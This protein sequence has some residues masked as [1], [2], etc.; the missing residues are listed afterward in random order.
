M[1]TAVLRSP[2]R[3]LLP[4]IAAITLIA[5]WLL[6][7]PLL[8]RHPLGPTRPP[9]LRSIPIEAR[10][11]YDRPLRDL[12]FDNTLF[13][14]VLDR[15]RDEGH[16]TIFVNW[17]ALEAAGV[18]KTHAITIRLPAGRLADALTAVT[19]QI[20]RELIPLSFQYDQGVIVISTRDDLS[21][22]LIVRVYDVRDLLK[23]DQMMPFLRGS[24]SAAERW[25]DEL[26]FVQQSVAPGSWRDNGGSVGSIR[27]IS[28]QFIITQ[29]EQN[30]REIAYQLE[31]RRWLRGVKTFGAR[32]GLLLVASLSLAAL[33]LSPLHRRQ[34]RRACGQCLQCGY[35][36]RATPDR[37]PECG[38]IVKAESRPHR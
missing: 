24:R 30:H 16:A 37:C 14:D 10:E 5:C 6:Y 9:P 23:N 1:I 21:P 11:L 7:R 32:S 36:L 29:T 25:N 3:V 15:L 27:A 35:D 19:H 28:D 13:A 20:A 31:R 38:A 8:G 2:L 26:T 22:N 33:L 12:N 17:R 18:K 4:R 34:R